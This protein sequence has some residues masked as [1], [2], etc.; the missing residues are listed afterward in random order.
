MNLRIGIVTNSYPSRKAPDQNTFIRD[1]V[2][3]LR[4]ASVDVTVINHRIN[5]AAMSLESLIRSARLDIL[6]AQF[7][8]PS[9]IVTA[10]TPRLAPFVVTVHRWDILEFPYKWPMARTATIATLR[11]ASGIVAVGHTIFSEV[12]KFA[13]PNSRIVIIP[14]AVDTS[15]FSPDVPFNSLKRTLNIPENDHVILSVGHLIPRKGYKTLLRAMTKILRTESHCTLVIVGEGFLHKK[16][17]ELGRELGLG[18]KLKFTGAVEDAVLPPLYAMA[19]VFVMPSTSEGHCISILEAMSTGKPIVASDIPANA[20]SVVEGRNGFLVPPGDSD[21]LANS[22]LKI[23]QED[24][25]RNEFGAY[26]RHRVTRE[27]GWK[28][29]TERLISFYESVLASN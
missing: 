5:L 12:T 4:S 14:N 3:H 26:S 20:E 24:I 18:E 22:I 21:A 8:A 28:Q 13:P 23:L 7:I 16:L 17:E 15:H 2:E 10:F 1:I 27:F 11:A 9:G 19:D 25:L 6:D 29:R